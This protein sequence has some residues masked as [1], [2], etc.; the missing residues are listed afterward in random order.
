MT[1]V[2]RI[3]F[4]VVTL[5]ACAAPISLSTPPGRVPMSKASTTSSARTAEAV[6]DDTTERPM[7]EVRYFSFEPTVGVYGWLSSD[8][9]YGLSA[10]LRRD[11]ALVRDHRLFVSTYYV[12]GAR[13]Y[14]YAA[15]GSHALLRTSIT[16]DLY[17]CWGTEECS[18]LETFGVRI[19]DSLVRTHGDSITVKFYGRNLE[20]LFITLPGSLIDAYIA[21]VDSTSA[22]LRKKA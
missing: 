7:V 16:R 20:D 13:S 8:N 15:L 1:L 18:P 12:P 10:R 17:H 3:A 19:P 4:V 9:G 14:P 11:G 2:V 6:A 22:A 5:G 21:T